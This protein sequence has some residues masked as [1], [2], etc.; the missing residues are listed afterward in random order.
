MWII[1]KLHVTSWIL[2]FYAAEQTH[3]DVRR[4]F[5]IVSL[6]SSSMSACA[7]RQ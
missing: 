5:R 6:T 3:Y 1:I 4:F 2:G 7:F